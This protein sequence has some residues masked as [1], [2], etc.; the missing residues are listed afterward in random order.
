MYYRRV[1][2]YVPSGACLLALGVL[3]AVVIVMKYRQGRQLKNY[4]PLVRYYQLI[5]L[6][7]Y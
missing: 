3:V 4:S 2:S 1:L 7:L 5:I 6:S